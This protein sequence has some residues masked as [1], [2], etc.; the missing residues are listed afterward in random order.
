MEDFKQTVFHMISFRLIGARILPSLLCLLPQTD[1]YRE[2]AGKAKL[3]FYPGLLPEYMLTGH[4]VCDDGKLQ[5]SDRHGFIF[6]FIQQN[7][8]LFPGF[9]HID[10]HT[11]ILPKFEIL[12]RHG[13]YTSKDSEITESDSCGAHSPRLDDEQ[14]LGSLTRPDE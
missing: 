3:E 1:I 13:F 12:R 6:D 9:F 14:V 2:Y 4:E 10:L 8:D 5:V 11:N 7:P